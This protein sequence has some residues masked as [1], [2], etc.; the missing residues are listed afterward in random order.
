MRLVWK[1]NDPRNIGREGKEVAIGDRTTI[2]SDVVEIVFAPP[3]HKPSSSG[4]IDVLF[5]NEPEE[6][7]NAVCTYYVSVIGAEWIE[8]E[9]RDD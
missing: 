6:G 7:D 2:D 9:D 1:S 4:K 3:P 8:R 5:V